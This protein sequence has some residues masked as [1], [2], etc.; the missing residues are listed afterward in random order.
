MLSIMTPLAPMRMMDAMIA[1]ALATDALLNHYRAAPCALRAAP[2]HTITES[3]EGY[4]VSLRAP[5]ISPSD[6]SI[7]V[8][9]EG[10]TITLR[11]ATK[12]AGVLRRLDYSLRLPR[13]SIALEATATVADGLITVSVPKAAEHGPTRIAVSADST[14][15]DDDD[16]Q[17]YTLT[18]VAAGIAPSDLELSVERNVLKVSGTSKRTGATVDRAY[19]LPRNADVEKA[20]AAHVDGILTVTVPKKARVEP[21]RIEVNAPAA[22][23]AMDTEEA[24]EGHVV[25][26]GD[27]H[28][29]DAA[30]EDAVL[31]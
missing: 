21:T 12:V 25:E 29:E 3:A 18:V 10:P 5:G 26:G 8:H 7:D 20:H 28:R 30:D 2:R 17:R 22:D 6:V 15:V 1:D 19:Q 24:T 16:E 27:A 31:V 11:G 23:A 14:P 4:V 9:E 13:D